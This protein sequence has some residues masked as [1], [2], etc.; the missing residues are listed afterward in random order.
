MYT[1]KINVIMMIKV[2]IIKT[3]SILLLVIHFNFNKKIF[4]HSFYTFPNT[5]ISVV[6]TLVSTRGR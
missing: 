1:N 4:S 5:A 3:T 2:I 6:F